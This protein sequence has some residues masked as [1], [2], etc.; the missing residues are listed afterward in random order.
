MAASGKFDLSSGSPD[1]PLYASG[2]RGSYSGALL[3][4][5]SSFRENM[6]NPILSALPSISRSTSP[7]AQGDVTNFLQCLRFDPKAM[8]ADQKFNR[9][10]D[11]KRLAGLAL[12]VPSDDSPSGSVKSNLASSL[13][14]E[15]KR[16][17][18]GLRES[19]IKAR[20]RVKTFS[21]GLSVFSKCFPGIP[22]R[23]RSRS[24][25]LSGERLFSSDR[26]VSGPPGGKM[27]ALS[28][29]VTSGFERDQQKS[30]ER[31]KSSIPNK[32]TR[33][34]MADPRIDV[35]PNTPAR[36]SGNADRDKEGSRLPNNSVT[37]V[38]D[39]TLPIGV[40]IWEKSKMKK[41]RSGIKADAAPS[42]IALKPNDG[43]REPRQGLQPKHLSESRSRL[44]DSNGL[45]PGAVNGIIGVVKADGASQPASLG[46]RSSIP[47]SEQDIASAPNEKRVT[48]SLDK[49]RVN[50]RAVNKTN[51]REEF[52]SASPTS[53]VKLNAASRAPRS[54]PGIVPKLSPVV[55][56]ATAADWEFSQ[57]TSKNPTAIGTNN[58]KRASS[59][60]CSSPPVAQWAGQRH[61]K[62]SRSA[63]R[64]NLVPITSNDE[65]PSLDTMSDAAGTENGS[66][67]PRRLSSN[68]PQQVRIKGDQYP[69]TALSESEESGAAEVKSKDKAKNSDEADNKSG[70]N[71]Q[72][73]AT[74]VVPPRKN[75]MAT[76]DDIGDGIRR[77]GRTGRGF[78]STRSL[79]P[80][81]MEKHGNIGTTKQLRSAKFGFDK[82]ES[83]TGRPPTRKLSDR[84]AY[85]RKHTTLNAAADFL[86]G[87]DDGH[88]ELLAA[89][90][91]V[92]ST[93]YASS[94]SF[95]RQMEQLFRFIS[96]VD[97]D[98][99]K[100]QENIDI[101]ALKSNLI[102]SNSLL[103]NGT[104]V[105]RLRNMSE[106]KYSEFSLDQFS[107]GAGSSSDVPL[108]QILL[109]ALISEDGNEEP[110]CS[111]NEGSEY[112]TY[113]SDEFDEE[114][115]PD[116]F[117]HQSLHNFE[118][119]GRTGLGGYRITASGRSFNELEHDVSEKDSF[120]MPGMYITSGVD[121]S[122]NDSLPKLAE[123]PV[124][125]C[126][127]FQYNKMSINERALLEIQSIGLSPEP[128]PDL[129]QTGDDEIS[130]DIKK[131]EDKYQEQVCRR[132]DF[133]D[134]LLKSSIESRELQ[135]KELE[136]SALEKLVGMAYQKYMS[137]WG[138]NAPGGKSA[139]GKMA[140][141][142]ALAFV[143]RTLA[144][145]VEFE[146]TGK[147]CFGEP[148]FRE[149]FLSSSSQLS[150]AQ[151][152]HVTRDGESETHYGIASRPSREGRISGLV[153][154]PQTPSVSNHDAYSP[155][156]FL[157]NYLPERN[158]GKE[159]TWS[160]RV[161][162]RELLLDDVVGGVVGTSPGISSGI[163]T[164]ISSSTKGKR[165]DRDRE[166]K[167]NNR[168]V[169]SR[170]GTTKNGR[171]TSGNPKVEKKSKLKS[172]QKTTQLSAVNGI[173]GKMS[174]QPKNLPSSIP[175]SGDN[176]REKDN[177]KL[178]VLDN[179]EAIDFS[180]LHMDGG[181]DVPDDLGDQGQDIGSWL[182]IDDDGLQDDDFM[183]LEIPM[184]D[185]SEL[186]MMV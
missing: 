178:D 31:I 155:G 144:R 81:T 98:Y 141:Q 109:S 157:G 23:K 166:G 146:V 182:N 95:W 125:F 156:G 107:P 104:V 63:R 43:Y 34:S 28:H 181:L 137:C 29:T 30:D 12:G 85:T 94:S 93:A 36:T 172:K 92:T 174:E 128:V 83:K 110:C 41:K 24:D 51:T 82:T 147:S 38:E 186:N 117:S 54:G 180:T 55:P 72:K 136:R 158:I 52:T 145:C 10:M 154:T 139:S 122:Q 100:R 89:A 133:L 135:E 116:S 161:K 88:E 168:E 108:C 140:K 48:T 8:V 101:T 130:R 3:D 127:D 13:P 126:S 64:T 67:F 57:C 42:S 2:Q 143:K 61:Q 74:L 16:F 84:K 150:D 79:V 14:E 111:E 114:V 18:L 115:E 87:S 106:G 90:N 77:Q 80:V 173:I 129:A 37:Q 119:A 91:A 162:K 20:E 76:G 71:V 49:E 118:L 123:K 45:R 138:P 75:K 26:S 165:S 103:H 176:G 35:R 46:V 131:L 99:L 153:G 17:K 175:K 32:R 47:R 86:V 124:L 59:T 152:M 7:V 33:T 160:N 102:P 185:L 184:D 96:E 68:S 60:Q 19:S 121:H 66:V 50:P 149:M 151:Q 53:S 97:I 40:D 78:S 112:N 73:T 179:T 113:G 58:R 15:V 9:P 56:R 11:F 134:K 105:D 22:S 27:G 120:S 4:R 142:A 148:L 183:G 159:D 65:T 171:T 163:G 6:E 21:E 167:G 62:N 70:K 169:L 69:S 170:N 5:S 39:R 177:F 164:S 132:K 44:N 1:R 25:V